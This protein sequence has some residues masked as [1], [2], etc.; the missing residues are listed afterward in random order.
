MQRLLQ[1]FGRVHLYTFLGFYFA[2]SALTFI[3]LSNGSESDRRENWILAATLGTIS[4]PFTGAIARHLQSCC[5]QFSLTLFPY[6]AT[7]LGV[8]IVSQL[9]PLPITRIERAVRLSLWCLGL[10]GWFGGVAVSFA[11]ALS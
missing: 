6:C 1:K 11:H 5:W 8:G 3:A 4:G 7:F 2:F 10:L 9:I